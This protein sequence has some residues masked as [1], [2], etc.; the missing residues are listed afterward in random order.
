MARL[1]HHLAHGTDLGDAAGIHHRHA[2]RGLGDDAHVVGDEHD[3]GAA[4]AAELL[5]ERDDLRLDR[6]IQ[7]RRRLVGDDQ[8][9]LGGQGQGDDDALA[10]AAGEFVGIAVDALLGGG[11]ADL[12]EKR[13][14]AVAGL[15]GVHIGMGLDRLDQLLGDAEER[16]QRG[17]R[18]LEDHADALAPDPAQRFLVEIVDAA[19]LQQHLAAGNAAR[20]IDEAD[21]G[22]AGERLARAGF[23]N[24]AQHL[25]LGDV[26][27]DAVDGLQ[28]ASRGG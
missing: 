3:G 26:E 10:H 11:D 24:D 25:A 12:G 6:D 17:Q 5:Q 28:D 23:A 18:I 27:G 22:G 20:R 2:V 1:L 16:V 21:D 19:A 4:L 15:G 13:D 9:R 8:L 14:G 7:R